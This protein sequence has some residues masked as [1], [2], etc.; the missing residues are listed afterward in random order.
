M[1][2]AVETSEQFSLKLV[3]F[4]LAEG[5]DIADFPAVFFQLSTDK[6]SRAIN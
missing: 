1:F 6:L 5:K 2:V 3:K 4:L